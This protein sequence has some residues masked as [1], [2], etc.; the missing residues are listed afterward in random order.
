MHKPMYRYPMHLVQ[1]KIR[2]AAQSCLSKISPFK[3][4]FTLCMLRVTI[5]GVNN[6]PTEEHS[7]S[8]LSETGN[9]NLTDSIP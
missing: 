2:S 8:L 1:F 4:E 5:R 6:L 3:C 7:L 9:I